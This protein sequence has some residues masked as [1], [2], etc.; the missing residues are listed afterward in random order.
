MWPIFMMFHF[1]FCIRV[2][3]IVGVTY[4]RLRVDLVAFQL[5]LS[6]RH[7]EKFGGGFRYMCGVYTAVSI[8]ACG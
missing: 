8:R 6:F 2:E 5:M 3:K 7:A 4:S 1:S